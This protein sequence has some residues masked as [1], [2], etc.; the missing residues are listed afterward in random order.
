VDMW[1]YFHTKEQ[2]CGA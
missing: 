1:V 2:A